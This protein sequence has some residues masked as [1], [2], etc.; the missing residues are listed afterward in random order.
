LQN[1]FAAAYYRD[2]GK[3]IYSNPIQKLFMEVTGEQHCNASRCCGVVTSNFM[4]VEI[5]QG[6]EQYVFQKK[7]H[8]FLMKESDH[9]FI[10]NFI[11]FP[12]IFMIQRSQSLSSSSDF[13]RFRIDISQVYA[14]PLGTLQ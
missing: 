10:G 3:L 14:K 9:F 7:F 1:L 8:H 5:A 12:L 2:K 11:S 13:A 6:Q 4:Q